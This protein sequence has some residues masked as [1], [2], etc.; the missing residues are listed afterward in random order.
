MT[1]D[2]VNAIGARMSDVQARHYRRLAPVDVG[3]VETWLLP[4][5]DRNKTYSCQCHV[6]MSTITNGVKMLA[7]TLSF[8]LSRVFSRYWLRY[9]FTF[10]L[11]PLTL[12]YLAG[13]CYPITSNR[14][15]S[16]NN[17]IFLVNSL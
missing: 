11:Q 7:I 3:V 2:N 15:F 1:V 12:D 4:R 17:R 6:V 8:V 9:D 14:S 13:M 16:Y 5:R 10:I